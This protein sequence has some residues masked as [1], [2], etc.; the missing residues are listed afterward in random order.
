MEACCTVRDD[1]PQPPAEAAIAAAPP[2]RW[3]LREFGARG[4][5]ALLLAGALVLWIA[6]VL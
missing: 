5:L 4:L 6:M 1:R 2:R 3:R